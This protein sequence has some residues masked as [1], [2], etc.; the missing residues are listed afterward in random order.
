MLT[1][2]FD[3]QTGDGSNTKKGRELGRK[4]LE[5]NGRWENV[6]REVGGCGVRVVLEVHRN[7]IKKEELRGKQ[8]QI[9]Q[10]VRFDDN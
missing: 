2:H 8:E 5:K 3:Y 7:H 6:V 4:G 9:Q 10:V 1:E